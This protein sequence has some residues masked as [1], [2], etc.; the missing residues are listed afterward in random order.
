MKKLIV[1]GSCLLAWT[2][3]AQSV[4]PIASLRETVDPVS[5]LPGDTETVFSVEGVV[6][7]HVN[8]TSS[9]HSLFYMQDD[10]AGIPVFWRNGGGENTPGA[11]DRVRVTAPLSH[12]RGL[13]Q[14]APNAEDSETSVTVLSMGGAWVEPQGF[15]FDIQSDPAAIEQIEGSLVMV[16]GVTLQTDDTTFDGGSNYTIED[17]S[18]NTFTLRIDSRTPF[19]G[20]EISDA[21][22]DIVGVVGQ[23]TSDE[24]AVGGYQIL[25]TRLSDLSWFAE[26]PGVS[27]ISEVRA[28]VD[29]STFLPSDTDTIFTVEGVVTTHVSLTSSSHSLFY[30]QDAS[31]GIAVFWRDG[32]VDN[33]PAA[34]D[35]VRVTAPL[36]DFRGLLQLTPNASNADTSVEVISSGNAIP[37][38]VAL[39]FG[40]A[41]AALEVVEGSLVVA[42]GVTLNTDDSVF[43]GGANYTLTD[44]AGAEFTLRI[45]SRVPLEGVAIPDGTFDVV[46]VLGQFT[47][48]EPALGGYQ[49]LPSRV[50][51]IMAAAEPVEAVS[52]A[53]VRQTVDTSTYLPSD[54]DTLFTVEGVVTTHVSL[55]SDSHSLF[56]MQDETAG[57]PVFWRDGGVANTPA[58][59]DLVRVTAPLSHFRG[60]LQLAP[61]ASNGDTSVVVLSSGNPL[62]EPVSL[63]FGTPD[64]D[65]E[66]L[67]GSLVVAEGVTIST[68]DTTFSGGSNLTLTDSAGAEFTL[69]IDSRTLF[70]GESI[71]EGSIDVIGVLGQ[72]T[73]NEP[74]LGGYQILPSRLAD[75]G[76]GGG[77]APVEAVEIAELRQ[78]VDSTS[79]LPTDTDTLF[80]VEGVVTTHVSL[81]SDSHSLFYLQDGSAGLAVFWRDAGVANTP[82]AGALVRVTAPL[83][84]FRG[85][86]QL[87][88]NAANPETSVTVVSAEGELPAPAALDLGMVDDVAA[89]EALEGTSVSL[90]GVTFV[91]EDAEF[92]SGA[93]YTVATE[94]GQEFTVR[95]DSRT[96][97]GGTVV[98]EGTVAIVGVLGQ[99]TTSEP[100]TGGYQ[101]FPT[102]IEDVITS[103]TV[104][105]GLS[106]DGTPATIA[107]LRDLVDPENLTPVDTDTIFAVEGVVTTSINLTTDSHVLFYMQEGDAGIAV[108]YRDLPGE[109]VPQ[110]GDRVRVVG[111]LAHFNGLLELVPSAGDP[112]TGMAVLA[113]DQPLPEAVELDLSL[114]NDPAAMDRLEASLVRI[115]DATI[116]RTDGETFPDPSG[117]L[118]IL[119]P[120]G[121]EFTLRVDSRTDIGG[122]SIPDGF[123]TV[124]GVV[125]QFD[126]SDPRSSGY[127][128]LPDVFSRLETPF[129]APTIEYS[130]TILNG[131]RPVAASMHQYREFALHP[132]E[133][134]VIEATVS[135]SAGRVVELSAV[136]NLPDG[137]SW[138]IPETSGEMLTARLELTAT[139]SLEGQ[140]I[141]PTLSASND[142]A[143]ADSSWNI[144]VPTAVEQQ[145]FIGE[146]MADPSADPESP[147]YNPLARHEEDILEDAYNPR[148][149]DEFVEIVNLSGEE[150]ELAG[151]TFSDAASLRHQ[152]F[153]SFVIEPGGAGIIYGGPANGLVPELEDIPV[154]PASQNDFLGLNN[155]GGD[156]LI[157]RNADGNVID[158]FRYE[159][160][161]LSELGSVTLFPDAFGVL[162]GQDSVSEQAATPGLSWDGVNAWGDASSANNSVA[163]SVQL[164][165]A[166][167]RLVWPTQSGR[168]YSIWAADS[169]TSEF[170]IWMV[171]GPIT[172]AGE[173]SVLLDVSGGQQFFFISEH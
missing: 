56:Y 160:E 107:E 134:A 61:N 165:D 84:Q 114:V 62:P 64:V 49:V 110:L 57:I 25:P 132:G 140:L 162:V 26:T 96:P 71:P 47:S 68:D 154:T 159:E 85:L 65:L 44:G 67:E 163:A 59:G 80:T 5:F 147:K 124:T 117:N 99:F 164:G 78:T 136:D 3:V 126:T 86:L 113:Q 73:S 172:D 37:D 102:R 121:D 119:G 87:A 115:T 11:G 15:S 14:L 48:N 142:A 30:L 97:F 130:I 168:T 131:R 89:I 133:T 18:G 127:Q 7:T 9:S 94:A 150:V 103:G 70:E 46:G 28:S 33:T 74:A 27:S 88:P 158:R 32:G 1:L 21:P 145:V 169:V 92:G 76:I 50:E 149:H 109:N 146:F 13:L 12:F 72:F 171:V 98:P 122:Q 20:Q 166:G 155:G 173:S 45:D 83:S 143:T 43:S 125:G 66:A 128:I 60:L 34:G 42:R 10:S 90:S 36:G 108:F 6:T 139:A 24:P 29:E 35:R 77:T 17:R 79:Y 55:T 58:A 141:Q 112:N 105:P 93:N 19:E 4:V 31:A 95:I 157:L 8:L 54:T 161:Q 152:F 170:S 2:C 101:L 69:R 75:L 138:S 41:D 16:E 63:G 116:D 81:T 52:I 156:E 129:K 51:D 39:D 100:A 53:A 38:A 151:W 82:P 120:N 104:D 135:D 111:P 144:Y 148:S 106:L 123:V 40:T 118:T 137:A 22:V 153:T 167:Y 23:F 91:T